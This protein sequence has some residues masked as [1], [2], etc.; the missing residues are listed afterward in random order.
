V[1]CSLNARASLERP[2]QHERVRP[3]APENLAE[4][5]SLDLDGRRIEYNA[6]PGTTEQR[7]KVAVAL[8]A[9]D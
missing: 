8:R 7:R 1:N 6:V 9:R 4:V 2:G 5:D 3:A